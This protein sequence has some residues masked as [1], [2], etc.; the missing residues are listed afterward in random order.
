MLFRRTIYL[1]AFIAT[2][3]TLRLL[4]PATQEWPVALWLGPLLFLI[5]VV[6]PF[7]LALDIREGREAKQEEASKPSGR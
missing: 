1:M 4:L 5:F 7:L 3:L 2:A 6:G